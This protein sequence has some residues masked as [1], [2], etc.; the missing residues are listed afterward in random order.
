MYINKCENVWEIECNPVE[1]AQTKIKIDMEKK[2]RVAELMPHPVSESSQEPSILMN[3]KKLQASFCTHQSS[4]STTTTFGFE[5][6]STTCWY[7][8]RHLIPPMHA[9]ASTIE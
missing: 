9:A 2:T 6:T 1:V 7:D 3:G 4:N 8:R 5:A